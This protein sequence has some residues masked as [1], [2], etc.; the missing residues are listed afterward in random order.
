MKDFIITDELL[1]NYYNEY[2]Q[3]DAKFSANHGCDYYH[4]C[5]YESLPCAST[6]AFAQENGLHISHRK[7]TRTISLMNEAIYL[8]FMAYMYA[9]EDSLEYILGR[10]VG[11]YTNKLG[12]PWLPAV[13]RS[14]T[15]YVF[16]H[17]IRCQE[18][19]E[20]MYETLEVVKPFMAQK[21]ADII[22]LLNVEKELTFIDKLQ[23]RTNMELGHAIFQLRRKYFEYKGLVGIDVSK[24]KIKKYLNSCFNDHF[25]GYFLCATN[26]SGYL[27]TINVSSNCYSLPRL[28]D[29]NPGTN[30]S[31]NLMFVAILLY[32][33][34][35]QQAILT[36][37]KHSYDTVALFNKY[38]GWPYISTG[39]GAG[40]YLH[41][42]KMLEYAGLLPLKS[43]TTLFSEVVK[44]VF[45]VLREEL[46][47]ALNGRQEDKKNS[48]VYNQFISTIRQGRIKHNIKVYMDNEA[49]NIQDLIIKW[50]E[51]S[52]TSCWKFLEENGLRTMIPLD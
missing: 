15:S 16:E 23:E 31:E 20:I 4:M 21:L 34:I 1:E 50:G 51:S 44:D 42:L 46:N 41:P 49:R 35:A 13:D 19:A 12:F 9:L 45:L 47:I 6:A 24:R 39:P 2:L 8:S 3:N 43:E 27:K 36:V 40:P 5:L 30:P 38:I 14:L 48:V 28:E 17:N 25:K 7:R 18:E 37:T 32:M 26:E 33:Y 52:A 11:T 22:G 29:G 10:E